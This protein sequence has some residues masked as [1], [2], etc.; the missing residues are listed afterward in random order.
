MEPLDERMRAAARSLEASLDGDLMRLSDLLDRA[1]ETSQSDRLRILSASAG[2]MLGERLIADHGGRWIDLAG[3]PA[4]ELPGGCIA[5]PFA[6]VEDQLNGSP[7]AVPAYLARVE[8]VLR[9]EREGD[10]R[11]LGLG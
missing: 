7:R 5:T 8:S 9:G 10:L 3:E 4:V 6:A 11:F 1:R 2:A